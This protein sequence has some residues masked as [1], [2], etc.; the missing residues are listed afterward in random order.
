[1]KQLQTESQLRSFIQDRFEDLMT[2]GGDKQL[3]E[4][5]ELRNKAI[6][7]VRETGFPT[8]RHEEYKYTPVTRRIMK[9]LAEVGKLG[10]E[11]GV[12]PSVN[13]HLIPDLKGHL[14]VFWNGRVVFRSKDLPHGL[15]ITDIQPDQ[16]APSQLIKEHLGTVAHHKT[17]VFTALNTAMF[18]H[19]VVIE[20]A[21]E[22]EVLEPVVLYH[23]SDQQAEYLQSRNLVFAGKNSSCQLIEIF[24]NTNGNPTVMH[25][26]VSEVVVSESANIKYHK[27]QTE[28]GQS[29]HV[30][31]THFIQERD[32][33]IECTCITTEGNLIRNNLNVTINGERCAAH[34]FGLYMLD[35][36]S[37]VDNHTMVDH[38]VANSFSN[39]LYKGILADNSTGVFN[40]KIFV[41]EGAQHTN[42]FQS[43][44]NILLSDQATMNTKPQLEIWAD[45]VK[46]SHG[47]TTGQLDEEQLFYLRTRGM[48]RQQAV[49][50]LLGAFAQETLEKVSSPVL[51]SYLTNIIQ[52][53]LKTSRP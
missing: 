18:S 36:S 44:K 3:P 39:E 32:S 24:K 25:N 4:V 43:N 46:C 9:T 10:K 12:I 17:D 27:I 19:G 53:K 29:V 20:V 45:D 26:H 47:A 13:E 1:M 2:R 11:P 33:E 37:H 15:K 8:A 21:S 30:G 42:A 35:D 51:K 34:L 16:E 28:G 31:N 14:V 7:S 48:D 23:L 52:Q 40:G 6:K 22:T 5:A 49:G 50:L 41:R 38:K